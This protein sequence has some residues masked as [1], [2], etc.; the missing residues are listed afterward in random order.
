M[1]SVICQIK[2]RL[3]KLFDAMSRDNISVPFFS[4]QDV[5]Q[6]KPGLVWLLLTGIKTNKATIPGNF[7]PKLI[8]MFAAYLAETL[9]NIINTSIK[10]GE[11]PHSNSKGDK[12]TMIANLIDWN[13]AFPRQCAKLGID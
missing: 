12:I 10:R 1:K 8:K 7:P 3:K 2:I 9:T 13:N 5:P 6:F 4:P 11:Y